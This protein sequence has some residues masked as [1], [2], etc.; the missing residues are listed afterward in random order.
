MADSVKYLDC[1]EK[2]D[3]RTVKLFLST[4]NETVSIR[5]CRKCGCHWFFRLRE[6][7]IA[8]DDYDRSKWYVRLTPEETEMFIKSE[9]M[10]DPS[11]FADRPGFL[12]DADGM[13]MIRGV[14]DQ[15][16]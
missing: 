16:L 5:R 13:S 10:P 9:T 2:P 3:L 8:T 14:P 6:Y 1:C 4:E 15:Q 12:R 7:S 11:L